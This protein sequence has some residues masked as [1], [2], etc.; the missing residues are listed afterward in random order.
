MEDEVLSQEE[1]VGST[2]WVLTLYISGASARSSRAVQ[3]IR[4]VCDTELAGN[5][6]L[7]VVDVHLHP[8]RLLADQVVAAPAVVKR[9]P[10]P[11]RRIVGDLSDRDKVLVALDVKVGVDGS[12]KDRSGD[13]HHA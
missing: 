11:L 2:R 4:D 10:L 13:A 3:R 8:E 9:L 6:E 1:A 5:V 7:E 12:A